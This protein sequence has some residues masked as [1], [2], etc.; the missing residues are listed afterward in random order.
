MSPTPQPSIEK[1]QYVAVR[2]EHLLRL[3]ASEQRRLACRT[4]LV[5]S[6]FTPAGRTAQVV[7]VQCLAKNNLHTYGQPENW[8]ATTLRIVAKNE[9]EHRT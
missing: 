8:A 7:S 1:G 9:L 2:A 4:G 5:L 3:S 6:A